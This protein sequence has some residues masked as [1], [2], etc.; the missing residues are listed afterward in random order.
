MSDKFTSK[1]ATALTE[2]ALAKRRERE[3]ARRLEMIAA[4]RAEHGFNAAVMVL[5]AQIARSA[6][7]G[8]G[9]VVIDDA[10]GYSDELQMALLDEFVT[11]R[12][13]EVVSIGSTILL[14]WPK[15]EPT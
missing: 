4:G 11:G 7:N 5:E 12:G 6:E 3:R 10:L 15:G 2:K 9:F 8:S 1:E 14:T 13:F